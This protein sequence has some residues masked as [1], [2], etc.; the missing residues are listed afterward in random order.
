MTVQR[1]AFLIGMLGPALQFLGVAWDL[2]EHGLLHTHGLAETT[3]TH[4]ISAPAHLLAAAG[5]LVSVIGIPVAIE[6]ARSDERE[7]EELGEVAAEAA[8]GTQRAGA[9]E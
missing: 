1:R 5:L 7:F 2:L 9:A 3:F 6:V 4:L 8:Y